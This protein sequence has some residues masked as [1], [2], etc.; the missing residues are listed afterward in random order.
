MWKGL[1]GAEL[2]ET[3]IILALPVCAIWLLSLI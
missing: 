2:G 3:I 1:K